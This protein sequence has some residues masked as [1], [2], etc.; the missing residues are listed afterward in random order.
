MSLIVYRVWVCDDVSVMEN[1]R[2]KIGE[3]VVG[4]RGN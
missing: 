3:L 2:V 1:I 4:L